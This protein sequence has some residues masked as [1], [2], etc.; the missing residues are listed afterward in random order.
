MALKVIPLKCLNCASLL[1]GFENDWI[2]FCASCQ[3][4][5][6]FS[7]QKP[8]PL[9]LSYARAKKLPPQYQMLFYLPFY[10]YQVSFNL[11]APKQISPRVNLLLQELRYIYVP[12]YQLLRESYFGDLGLIYT[13][14]G[15]KLEEETQLFRPDAQK[16]GSAT[17]CP[18]DAKPYLNYYPLLI[19]DKKQD[20]TGM[21][22]KV[23][24]SLDRIWAIP[25]FDLGKEIQEGI[26]GKT[27]PL[28]ALETI[29]EFRRARY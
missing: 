22:L 17:R 24:S 8:T 16:I 3:L 6:D 13:E 14:A 28:Y 9:R 12:A 19:I 20:I 1:N 11:S 27:F 26:L 21:E 4:G 23:N 18:S 5:W 25:F 15:I 10:Y 7:A 29:D 2:F